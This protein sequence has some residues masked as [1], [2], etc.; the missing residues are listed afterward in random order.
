L[1]SF[2]RGLLGTYRSVV[3]GPPTLAEELGRGTRQG[4]DNLVTVASALLMVVPGGQ[5]SGAALLE[6]RAAAGIAGSIRNVNPLRSLTNCVNCAIATDATLAG[7]AASALP[8]GATQ[9]ALLESFFGGQFTRVSGQS[10]IEA[11][12]L[13]A[14]PGARGIVFGS[15][16]AGEVGHV[17]NAVN[18]GGTIRFLDGQIG[19]AA[20]FQGFT[21]FFFLRTF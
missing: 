3:D 12:M 18:Q 17:F 8:S 15:R 7:R 14:G 11:L 13:G 6:T 10:A 4:F 16:G 21:E 19:G 1:P 2:G 5:P 9:I 20:S